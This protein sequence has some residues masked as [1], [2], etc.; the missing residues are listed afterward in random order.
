MAKQVACD[1]CGAT[2][3]LGWLDTMPA[4]WFTLTERKPAGED[5]ITVTCCGFGCVAGY[6]TRT[7]ARRAELDAA[8]PDAKAAGWLAVDTRVGE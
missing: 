8:A 6:A 3:R 4:G 5:D 1:G 2:A 7:Q